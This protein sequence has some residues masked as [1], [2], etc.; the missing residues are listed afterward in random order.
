MRNGNHSLI[1]FLV[2]ILCILCFTACNDNTR[3]SIPVTGLYVPEMANLDATMLNILE[4]WDIPGAAV[5][6]VKDGRLVYSRGFGYACKE[7]GEPVQPHSM[8]RIASVSKTITGVTVMKLVQDG[9]LDIDSPVFGQKGILNDPEYSNIADQRVYGITVRNLL[10]H[11]GGWNSSLGYDPQYDLVNIANAMGVPPPADGKSIIR[12]M[13]Q[14]P[15]D[16]DPGT[17]YH[18]SNLGYNI[19]GRVIEKASRSQMSYE[20]YVKSVILDPLG[21]DKM[22]IAGNLK[23][24]RALNEGCYYD[25]PGDTVP[26][27]Y[28]TGEEAP[29]SYGGL[30]FRAMNSHGGW[31]AST[32]DLLRFMTAVDGFDTRPDIL[33]KPTIA[34]MTTKPST[35]VSNYA[36]GWVVDDANNWYHTGALE[37]GTATILVRKN[38]GIEYAVLFN[39]LP[40]DQSDPLNSLKAFFDEFKQM[41]EGAISEVTSWPSHDLFSE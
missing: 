21:A 11:T 29:H 13:L 40:L 41:V 33:N 28:G 24:N 35:I 18:Y 4:K 20:A 3:S 17:E 31:I 39:R 25:I 22:R 1:F 38:N 10:Q 27:I 8:F 34:L 23:Q 15:L 6:V 36:M 14:I 37:T 12:Y 26:S 32:T 7:S 30:H 16:F 19:L 5:G 2:T 9:L